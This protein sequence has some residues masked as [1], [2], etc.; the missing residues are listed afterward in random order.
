MIFTNDGRY[1]TI[2]VDLQRFSVYMD[3]DAKI[4]VEENLN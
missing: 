2:V 3:K 1:M 4:C